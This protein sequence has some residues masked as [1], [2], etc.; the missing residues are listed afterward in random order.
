M[1]QIEEKISVA[2]SSIESAKVEV[3]KNKEEMEKIL[4][5]NSEYSRTV[6]QIKSLQ[7]QKKD[8]KKKL[9]KENKDLAMYRS[10]NRDVNWIRK[11]YQ[12]SLSD[13]LVEFEKAT[14]EK[15]YKGRRILTVKKL[16]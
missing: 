11:Q 5:N 16:A 8:I 14:G 12:L 1:T 15:K 9:F 2:I 13:L 4:N 6:V 3:K 10:K 7:D